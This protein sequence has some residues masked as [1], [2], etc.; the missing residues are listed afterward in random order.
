MPSRQKGQHGQSHQSMIEQGSLL[1]YLP[2]KRIMQSKQIVFPFLPMK[3]GLVTPSIQVLD[4]RVTY[5]H[6]TLQ[7]SALTP[8]ALLLS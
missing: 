4:S 3:I 2:F 5:V 6:L 1:E 7:T 8:Q